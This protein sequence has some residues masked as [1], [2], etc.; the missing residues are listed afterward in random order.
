MKM[1]S[2]V[3]LLCAVSLAG[4]DRRSGMVMS[5]PL[6]NGLVAVFNTVCQPAVPGT[7]PFACLGTNELQGSFGFDPNVHILSAPHSKTWF[8]YSFTAELTGHG[9]E[10][11]LTLGAASASAGPKGLTQVPLPKYDAGPFTIA[12]GDILRMPLLVNPGTGQTLID[13][14]QIFARRDAADGLFSDLSNPG[15]PRDFRLED[16]QMRWLGGTLF[17]NGKETKKMGTSGATGTVIWYSY[18][19]AG[20]AVFTF[21]PQSLPGFSQA[22]IVYGR[23]LRFHAGSDEYEWRCSEPILPGDGT[24]KLY[25]YWDAQP[26]TPGGHGAAST[27]QQALASV[28]R[29]RE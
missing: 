22:G 26:R 21:L 24:Y 16:V 4:A 3:A 1:T 15:E 25:V 28:A 18:E 23:T 6:P 11:R 8:G 12:P 17:V 19:D 9:D 14:I 20:T 7:N 5:V 13:E 29:L 2:L 27:A 10:I